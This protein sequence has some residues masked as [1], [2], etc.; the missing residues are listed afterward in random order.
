MAPTAFQKTSEEVG[1][2]NG[3]HAKKW[4]KEFSS[5]EKQIVALIAFMAPKGNIHKKIKKIVDGIKITYSRLQK[6]DSGFLEVITTPM[7]T[8]K[9]QTTPSSVKD[10]GVPK[11]QAQGG[12]ANGTPG[13]RKEISP[14][15]PEDQKKRKIKRR[16]KP[17]HLEP[18]D[19]ELETVL[20][21]PV[22]KTKDPEW[23]KVETKKTKT[24]ANCISR[25]LSQ[26]E[27]INYINFF[28]LCIFLLV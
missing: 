14:L 16:I 4:N 24:A 7:K 17:I 21:E 8:D 6:L 19:S 5:L 2:P 23:Q 18:V 28:F 11:V 25:M 15:Q 27:L 3:D 9:Q 1:A 26:R 13:K 12:E 20:Q 10:T 22:H